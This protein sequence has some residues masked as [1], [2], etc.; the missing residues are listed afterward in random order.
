MVRRP[1]DKTPEPPGGR[2]A[3][4]LRM[5]ELARGATDV[6]SDQRKGKPRK[7]SKA[8]A[9]VKTGGRAN[10]KQDRRKD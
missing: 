2:A 5:F 8:D 3:E 4:R 6:A 9:P 10:E 7:S 1:G